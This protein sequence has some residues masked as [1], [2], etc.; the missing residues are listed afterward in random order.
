MRTTARNVRNNA[1]R[2]ASANHPGQHRGGSALGR[3]VAKTTPLRAAHA[4]ALQN[5]P[6]RTARVAQLVYIRSA[7]KG[8]ERMGA[9][10]HFHYRI[11]GRALRDRTALE[12]IRA[13]AIPPAWTHVWI[14]ADPNG[15]LQATGF[16]ARGRKQYRYHADWSRVRGE[17]KFDHVLRFGAQLPAMRARLEQ[18]MALPDL[19]LNKVLATVVSVMERTH[20]R[21]GQESY[22]R[23]NGS[24]GLSTLKDKHVTV[25]GGHL[26]FVFRGKTGIAH[27]VSLRSRKLSKL[28]LRCKDL[29]GQDLFQYLDEN[30]EPHPIT[31]GQVNDYI[32]EITNGSYT[33]KDIRTWKGT[34]LALQALAG[35]DVPTS[36]AAAQRS[37]NS[38]LDEV[39]AQLGNTRSVCRKHYVHPGVFTG[40]VDG[41][42]SSVLRHTRNTARMERHERAVL[43]LLGA[44][45]TVAKAA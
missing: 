38:A 32:R 44:K 13:L 30:E 24:Y 22:A 15:H 41:I 8:I 29:P 4:T 16:D 9:G 26:R 6:A 21:V 10:G 12:R 25:E 1:S 17:V 42:L 28:V 3:P 34:V 40:F 31:S 2:A 14:C 27:A 23:E 37:I 45:R 20:I 36:N 35:Y 5:D 19:P 33:S 39:A 43:K 18:D 7:S 11:N